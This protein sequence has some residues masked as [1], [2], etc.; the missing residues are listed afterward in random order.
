MYRQEIEKSVF[1]YV[2]VS[3]DF[4]KYFISMHIDESNDLI[5]WRKLK[6]GKRFSNHCAIK[7]LMNLNSLGQAKSFKQI[8]V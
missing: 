4:D 5:P 1:E 7:L 6:S 8:K 3:S 2:F